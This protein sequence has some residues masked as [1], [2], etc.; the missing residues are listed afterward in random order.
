MTPL[1]EL[2]PQASAPNSLIS[3]TACLSV[4]MLVSAL[5][6]KIVNSSGISCL[7]KKTMP[8]SVPFS[9]MA[10]FSSHSARAV[11]LISCSKA[12]GY[13]NLKHRAPLPHVFH[14]TLGLSLIK[15]G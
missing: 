12:A 7:E 13:L 15:P 4:T 9:V 14:G 11:S 5:L 10:E 6:E 3:D 1:Q 2:K 8:G